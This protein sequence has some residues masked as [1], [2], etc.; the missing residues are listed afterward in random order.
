MKKSDIKKLI[1]ESVKELK[2]QAYGHATLTSQGQ[3]ISGAPGVWETDPLGD[4]DRKQEDLIRMTEQPGGQQGGKDKDKDKEEKSKVKEIPPKHSPEAIGKC[5]AACIDLEL[6]NLE[7]K[8]RNLERKK[9]DLASKRA[10]ARPSELEN[11]EKERKEIQVAQKALDD[12]IEAKKLE[13]EKMLNPEKEGVKESLNK[14]DMKSNVKKLWNDYAKSRI[15]SSLKNKISEQ[16]KRAKRKQLQEGVMQTFF[17][18]F[19]QGH[20]NEE[21]VQLY[22]EKGVAVPEQFVSK[23]RKQHESYSKMKFELEMSEKA[24]KNEAGQIVNNPVTGEADMIDD[25]KQ[26]ASGILNVQ[27]QM[28]DVGT[29]T[30]TK[31]QTSGKPED[32]KSDVKALERGIARIDQAAEWSQVFDKLMSK[33]AADEITGLT[34]SKVK[35]KLIQSAKLLK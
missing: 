32:L 4:E 16:R 20:T 2:E 18:Y 30:N 35:A 5:K 6:E 15:N 3:S 25:E 29:P 23:A 1:K 24:F 22:A 34:P 17:E 9:A 12:Q 19:D 33:I 31:T 7:V 13:K 27:E 14:K 8:D 11:I 28:G 26:L 21:I 10:D